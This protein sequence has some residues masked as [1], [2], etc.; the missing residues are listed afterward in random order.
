MRSIHI[1]QKTGDV[2]TFYL[3]KP[4]GSIQLKSTSDL[5]LSQLENS[6]WRTLTIDSKLY[7]P[8][9]Q[10]GLLAVRSLKPGYAEAVLAYTPS[11]GNSSEEFLVHCYAYNLGIDADTNRDGKIDEK[12]EPG[13]GHWQWGKGKYGAIVLVNNI[14]RLSGLGATDR[15]KAILA[16]LQVRSTG[17]THPSTEPPDKVELKLYTTPNAAKRFSIYRINDTTQCLERVLGRDRLSP[18]EYITLSDPLNPNGEMLYMEALQY[19]DGDFE[20][21]ITIELH[22]RVLR[23]QTRIRQGTLLQPVQTQESAPQ[24]TSFYSEDIVSVEQPL[25]EEDIIGIDKA[26]FRVAPWIMTPNTQRAQKVYT[27]LLPTTPI[28]NAPFVKSL[29]KACGDEGVKLEVLTDIQ[30]GEDPW[31][32]D[33]VEFGYSQNPTVI[34]EV[35]CRSTRRGLLR[36]LDVFGIDLGQ[37]EMLG[38][39]RSDLDSFGNLEVSPPVKVGG[40]EYPFGRIVFGGHAYNNNLEAREMMP[41]IRRFLYAQKVQ[42][43][44]EIFTDWLAVGHV[45]EIAC[46]VPADT[47]KRFKLLLASPDRARAILQRLRDTGHGTAK[48]FQGKKRCDSSKPDAE[49]T[50]DKLLSNEAFWTANAEFQQNMNLNRAIFMRELDLKECDIVDLPALFIGYDPCLIPVQDPPTGRTSAFYPN[51]VNHLVLGMTSVVPKPHGPKIGINKDADACC[52]SEKEEEGEQGKADR[53]VDVFEQAFCQSLPERHVLFIDDWNSYYVNFGDV[54][55][56]TNTRRRPFARKMW[57]NYKP[58]EAFD[59]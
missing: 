37:V 14:P 15:R 23:N 24:R 42:A 38:R 7:S 48:M 43:P 54:H 12:D 47:A 22:L 58:E 31:I 3:V 21:L 55:C 34:K 51:L 46:F 30:T 56:A 18:D 41:T 5:E 49:T 44:F 53:E 50:V 20:G 45:D 35:V 6:R 25:V 2:S 52:P 11:D 29:K 40:Q 9:P 33:S 17:Y 57:W 1:Y 36:S 8:L 16:P 19:P 32:Q 13:R 27:C 28:E 39:E 10:D 4:K 59:V 26:V